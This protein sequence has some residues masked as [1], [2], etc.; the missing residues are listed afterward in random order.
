MRSV[1]SILLAT[2]ALA[3][4]ACDAPTPPEPQAAE[5]L[6]PQASSV[7][8]RGRAVAPVPLN[9]SGRNPALVA[10]GSLLVHTHACSDCHTNPPFAEG[11]NP[12]LGQPTL[13]NTAGYLAGGTEFGP[14]RS[15]NIT[16]RGNGRPAGMTRDEFMLVMRTGIDL[17]NRHPQFGPLLQVMPWP[18]FRD[19][20]DRELHA[21][22]E[23]LSAI[24]CVVRPDQNPSRCDP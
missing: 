6:A 5:Q 21:I 3:P 7:I 19:M 17:G 13:V 22:Y 1:C 15:R 4:L 20:S 16:P 23:Y 12:F 11:G 2:V 9:M 10:E 18:F 14:F 24:P 8:Q